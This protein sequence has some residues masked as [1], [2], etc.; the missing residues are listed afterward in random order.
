VYDDHK[1]AAH[2][3]LQGLSSGVACLPLA[4]KVIFHI[5]S[6]ILLLLVFERRLTLCRASHAEYE[7]RML[8]KGEGEGEAANQ[9][10]VDTSSGIALSLLCNSLI[11]VLEVMFRIRGKTD[12]QMGPR[13]GVKIICWSSRCHRGHHREKTS[14]HAY[15]QSICPKF[16]PADKG[17]LTRASG[18]C[19]ISNAPTEKASNRGCHYW[20]R[21][22]FQRCFDISPEYRAQEHPQYAVLAGEKS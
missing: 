2:K 1:C 11:E 5:I 21:N 20:T 8:G 16:M 14:E 3:S 4:R 9:P 17:R 22:S 18:I 10:P 6:Y 15:V 7:M 19:P 13:T 12:Q